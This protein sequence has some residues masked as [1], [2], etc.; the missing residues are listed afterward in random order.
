[1]KN[2]AFAL[3]VSLLMVF[4][5]QAR[6]E[7]DLP[8]ADAIVRWTDMDTY[9][10]SDIRPE[11]LAEKPSN[12][13]DQ[14]LYPTHPQQNLKKYHVYQWGL[15]DHNRLKGSDAAC[16]MPAK[17]STQNPKP[18]LRPQTAIHTIVSDTF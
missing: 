9:T 3:M 11:Q 12:C 2:T 13:A 6:A 7:S 1:M 15:Y 14:R 17:M 10:S 8:N 5:L 4:G 18:C 16:A